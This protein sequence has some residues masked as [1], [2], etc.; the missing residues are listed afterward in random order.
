MGATAPL[1]RLSSR[2]VE[3]R[4][5]RRASSTRQPGRGATPVRATPATSCPCGRARPGGRTA[6][7]HPAPTRPCKPRNDI[8]LPSGHRH[9]GDHRRRPH[10]TCTDDVRHRRATPLKEHNTSNSGRSA[11]SA[12]PASRPQLPGA[13]TGSGANH[14]RPR[15]HPS[16]CMRPDQASGVS[17]SGR[18]QIAQSGRAVLAAPVR[19]R[20]HRAGNTEL[21]TDGP[22]KPAPIVHASGRRVLGPV[23]ATSWSPSPDRDATPGIPTTR[24]TARGATARWVEGCACHAHSKR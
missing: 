3:C 23:L 12:P 15:H 18:S 13:G 1:A 2:S 7:H 22:P 9:R 24:A 16:A 11:S 21:A 20:E 4:R 17:L 8:D 5:A 19:P 10:K 14:R 6:E